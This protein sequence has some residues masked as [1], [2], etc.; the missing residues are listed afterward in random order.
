MQPKIISKDR[1]FITGFTGDGSKT[2]ELWNDFDGKYKT[3][4][5][6]KV[7]D[8]G[9]EIRFWNKELAG[10]DVHVGFLTDSEQNADRFTTLIIPTSEYAVF[11]VF[12]AKGYDSGNVE[13]DKWLEENSAILK[14]RDLDGNGFII[15][16]YGERFK[17]GNKPDSIVEFWVPFYRF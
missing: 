17:D 14:N 9:Y 11:D 8:S 5:F 1:F 6:P 4:P 2:G 12:V 16:Y 7:G 13:M 10:R 3:N 15:E